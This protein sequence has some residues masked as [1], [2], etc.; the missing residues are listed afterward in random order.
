M[1]QTSLI[2]VRVSGDVKKKADALFSEL[3]LDTPTAIRI[4]LNHSIRRE[5]MPFEVA[6]PQPNADTLLAMLEGLE[7]VPKSYSNFRELLN[8]A[9]EEV[10]TE[11][12]N[13]V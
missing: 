2:Q 4:F 5:G 6:R 1:S 12:D 8:E 10:E 11:E 13:E 9:I 3:G 7:R